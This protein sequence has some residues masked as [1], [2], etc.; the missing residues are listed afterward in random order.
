MKRWTVAGDR[1]QGWV[2]LGLLLVAAWLIW[3]YPRLQRSSDDLAAEADAYLEQRL[4]E[5]HLM[6]LVADSH[7]VQDDEPDDA[8]NRHGPEAE[9]DI[10]ELILLIGVPS[11]P[12][13]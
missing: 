13:M 8:Q 10:H 2:L 12:W 5:L 7:E 6:R 11:A 1:I 4:P 3:C 9:G